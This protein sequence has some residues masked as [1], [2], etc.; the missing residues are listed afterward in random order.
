M[1]TQSAYKA[2]DYT[3]G[4]ICALPVELAASAE[5]LDKEHPP[6]PQDTKDSNSYTFG[7]IGEHNVVI[8]CLPFG[9][10]G[11]VSAANIAT[12]MKSRFKS[13]RFGLMV[14]IGGG[15]PSEISDI[16]LGDV[17]VSL[18][19]GQ[20][21]GVVQYDLGKTLTGG[22][23]IRTGSLNAPPQI[24][25][26][27]LAAVEAAR[28]RGKFDIET[29]LSSLGERLPKFAHPRTLKDHLYKSEYAHLRGATCANCHEDQLEER[30]DRETDDVI[31]HY[32]T[33]A[34]GN[35]V[36]K[37]GIERDRL[38]DELGGVLCFEMEA[39]GLMN[40]FPC[41]VIRGICDYA[42]SHK[43][44]GWQP[45]AA[46]TA[47][48]FGKGLLGLIPAAE[49][50][51]APTLD[52]TMEHL[53]AMF[54]D[55][56]DLSQRIE[57][58][59]STAEGDKALEWLSNT[60]FSKPQNT[61]RDTW[62]PG[63]GQW[64]LELKEYTDWRNF[65][66]GLLWIYGAAGSG[67][68]VLCSTVIDDIQQKKKKMEERQ[69]QPQ[70]AYWYFQFSNDATQKVRNLLRS[71]IRQLSTVSP[72]DG[73]TSLWQ[74]HNRTGSEPGNEELVGVLGKIIESH[75]SGVYL[76]M[77]ALDECPQTPD[78]PE[79]AR[80]LS[81]LRSLSTAHPN[82]HILVMSRPEL[83]IHS[84]LSQYPSIDLEM[85]VAGDVKR[86]VQSSL[87]SGDLNVWG[88]E[89]K[90]EIEDRLS[91]FETKRFR[92]ADLQIRRLQSCYTKTQIQEALRTIPES[93]E[94]AYEET[95]NSIPRKDAKVARLILMW[96]S[97]SFRPMT[98]NEIAAAVE[99]PHPEFVLKICTSMLVTLIHEQTDTFIK[100]AH[101]SVK[102]YLVAQWGDEIHEESPG[103]RFSSELAHATIGTATVSYI[104]GTNGAD[105]SGLTLIEMPLLSYSADYWFP[106][107]A[108]VGER[109][110]NFP[111]LKSQLAKFF[112]PEYYKS[113]V[114]WHEIFDWDEN[115][116]G[117][118]PHASGRAVPARCPLYCASL[119]GFDHIV[120]I[121]LGEDEAIS[122]GAGVLEDALIGAAIN[123]HS[124]VVQ[125]LLLDKRCWL[126]QD[127]MRRILR[128]VNTNT[129]AIIKV[130]WEAGLFGPVA[131]RARWDGFNPSIS[132]WA[133]ET[134]AGSWKNGF[135]VTKALLDQMRP[136]SGAHPSHDVV[137]AA[138]RNGLSGC[139]V[140]K[141]FLDRY[142]KHLDITDQ[143]VQAAAGNGMNGVEVMTL[144]LDQRLED[145]HITK[146]VVKEAAK[147][148]KSGKRILSL[149]LERLQDP[150]AQDRE[151]VLE[152]L[153]EHFDDDLTQ[154]FLD[155][156]ARVQITAKLFTAAAKNF[157]HHSE[158]MKILIGRQTGHDQDLED[159]IGAHGKRMSER[160]AAKGAAS[161]RY[162]KLVI[163]VTATRRLRKTN[164]IYLVIVFQRNEFI[165]KALS[166]KDRDLDEDILVPVPIRRSYSEAARRRQGSVVSIA[167]QE[168]SDVEEFQSSEPV[169]QDVSATFDVVD[170]DSRVNI[171]AYGRENGKETFLGHNELEVRLTATDSHRISWLPLKGRNEIE[172]DAWGEV[173]VDAHF[174]QAE[175]KSCS[176]TDFQILKLIGKGT[177]GQVYQVRKKDT[178][179]I[180]AMKVISKKVIV[181]KKGVAS[182]IGQRN[183]LVRAA[184]TNSPFIASLKFAFQTPSDL[185]LVTDYLA[186]GELFW[187]LQKEGRFK[188]ER[189]RFYVAEVI[190]ALQ[191][192]HSYGIIYRDL[193]P[194]NILLD[195][196]GHVVLVDFSLSKLS[197]KADTDD[198]FCGTTEYLAP[199]VILDEAGYTRMADFWSLGVLMFEMCCGWSPFYAEDTQQMYRNIA[200]GKI[201]F[202]RDAL[203]SDGRAF[204][205][206]LINRNPKHRLGATDDAEELK[207]HA[208]FSG[209]DWD[210]LETKRIPPP[211]KPQV[212]TSAIT[213]DNFDPDFTNA[214]NN[215]S[216]SLNARAAALAGGWLGGLGASTPLSPSMQAA[217]KGFTFVDESLRGGGF[218]GFT[219]VDDSALQSTMGGFDQDTLT[220]HGGDRVHDD[221]RELD[222]DEDW[223]DIKDINE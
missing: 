189:A 61:A 156:S 173:E 113:Y 179:R 104:L 12:Q 106:H 199:E 211:F 43:N 83:D 170:S 196:I 38:S 132:D 193:K 219:F 171:T 207:R 142:G 58:R 187:H 36:M 209:F 17:V 161:T 68:T 120:E 125:R 81:M 206:G 186:G 45:Y 123:G 122:S 208:F 53:T 135:E 220:H 9:Q 165:S 37:D 29:S 155:R 18:P 201:R 100:L 177:W 52:K 76:I 90:Q 51:L 13:I 217:F 14:G 40:N 99:L 210:A 214:L 50:V 200:F 48:A 5:L 175:M 198:H 32:G 54:A 191:H 157:K 16:R 6:L 124:Q 126:G 4:W 94:A 151:G 202:P 55:S 147:N 146:E 184:T 138:V 35:Q 139:E 137:L 31:I 205:K 192:L 20:S 70:L 98:I 166:M 93:L 109:I 159:M 88:T 22:Q 87:H 153:V 84:A 162:G 85:S 74:D 28:M 112:S 203:S 105:V 114:N 116:H 143:V 33:I 115:E 26:T 134:A 223:E 80:M 21:G 97:S 108:A 101:F 7:N 164:D 213:V 141:L 130:L 57:E 41:L 91:S 79:R 154:L 42:D 168:E 95:L 121:L 59:I 23:N 144:L 75:K 204:V 11:L 56:R 103:Y 169:T 215:T 24:L 34:S 66:P 118:I 127:H 107:V 160:S 47:A 129:H 176:A 64:L 63:T 222:K 149:L 67:K 212:M 10:M 3:V 71:F 131:G 148:T 178:Q 8:G 119:F 86:F 188:E 221:S 140:T 167:D 136:S 111:Q 190:L 102:E 180:Y 150:A 197:L 69:Q 110:D 92:W 163:K 182:I 44:K 145:I 62:T 89:L 46:A 77:D 27:A 216:S 174:Q 195:A 78:Q 2:E 60:T 158:I 19:N 82:L 117:E 15:V 194:E 30:D 183:V 133:L 218:R 73:V 172:S 152:V 181:R 39:A 25:L 1:A 65:R 128:G 49:V 185:Y 96:L 72:S